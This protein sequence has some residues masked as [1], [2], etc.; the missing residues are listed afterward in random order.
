MV[1]TVMF[2]HLNRGLHPH[3]LSKDVLPCTLHY[4][5]KAGGPK[6]KHNLD[7]NIA[8]QHMFIRGVEWG[9]HTRF[10]INIELAF[11]NT[12]SATFSIQIV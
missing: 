6:H 9:I 2:S 8:A 4:M 3:S 12:T 11:E 1:N 10:Y 7:N 5:L